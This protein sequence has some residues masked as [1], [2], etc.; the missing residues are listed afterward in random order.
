MTD[1]EKNNVTMVEEINPH[2]LVLGKSG[3]GKTF[4]LMNHV[5]NSVKEGKRINILDF[6]GSYTETEIAKKN[7]NL[8]GKISFFGGHDKTPIVWKN[9]YQSKLSFCEDV[10]DS[11]IKILDVKSYY[12]IKILKNAVKITMRKMNYFSFPML[13]FALERVLKAMRGSEENSVELMK[14]LGVETDEDVKNLEHLYS[15]LAPYEH[16]FN[17]EIRSNHDEGELPIKIFQLYDMPLLKKKFLTSFILEMIQNELKFDREKRHCDCLVLD[18]FQF[19]PFGEEDALASLLREGRRYGIQMILLT[20]FVS[21][22]SKAEVAALLQVGQLLQFRP[23]DTDLKF[24]AN[25]IDPENTSE[26]KKILSN[27]SRGEAVL[28]GFY[29]INNNS[30]ICDKPIVCCI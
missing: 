16:I 12:Q 6:S 28:K 8:F 21:N 11:I 17:F 13:V 10:A 25:L 19:L 1:R 3:T 5:E 29:T 14:E 24:T 30:T 9:N 7:P 27:L 18:E 2:M 23:A 15:R 4:F 26:W 22:Y 20:Q